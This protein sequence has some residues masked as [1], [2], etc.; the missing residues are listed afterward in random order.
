[1]GAGGLAGGQQGVG[2]GSGSQAG[3][4]SNELRN[5]ALAARA[6]APRLRRLAQRRQPRRAPHLMRGTRRRV[7]TRSSCCR[8]QLQPFGA[9]RGRGAGACC[10]GTR[11]GCPPTAAACCDR[12]LA[13]RCHGCGHPRSSTGSLEMMWPSCSL[14]RSLWGRSELRLSTIW[15]AAACWKRCKVD[16]V[17]RNCCDRR[18]EARLA[19]AGTRTADGQVRSSCSRSTMLLAARPAGEAAVP[20]AELPLTTADWRKA[21]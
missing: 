17:L 4:S 8:R 19:S 14:L 7:R 9:L 18:G 1:M 3:A 16:P 6:A 15:E 12:R 11:G 10:R 5:S 20:A 13:G 2:S 21:C